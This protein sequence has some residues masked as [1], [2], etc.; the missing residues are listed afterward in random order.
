MVKGIISVSRIVPNNA[1]DIAS[2]PARYFDFLAGESVDIYRLNSGVLEKN[3][4]VVGGGGLVDNSK[5]WEDALRGI[6]RLSPLAIAWGIGTNNERSMCPRYVAL[7]GYKMV[8]CRD[9]G[10]QF[11]WVPCSSCMSPLMDKYWSVVPQHETVI[12]CHKDRKFS[13]VGVPEMDNAGSLENA[14]SFIASGDTVL[15][16][17]YHGMYWATLLGR[18]VVVVEPFST[19]FYFS[20]HRPAMASQ[21]DIAMTAR[22]AIRYP[23]A[24]AECR[25]AN[26]AFAEKVQEMISEAKL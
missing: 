2:V 10:T 25:A 11:E 19:R 12:Y 4:V 14:L 8:G 24:L 18:R 20:K 26:L 17:S 15:T 5:N 23:E 7:R 9:W 16:N 3:V 21:D 1:G 13:F 22:V 6:G